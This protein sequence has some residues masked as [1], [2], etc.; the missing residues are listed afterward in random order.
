MNATP[1]TQTQQETVRLLAQQHD[2]KTVSKLSGVDYDLV[3]QW[4]SRRKRRAL[5][6]AGVTLSQTPVKTVADNVQSELQ[7]HE[8][9]TKLGL[10]SYASKQAKHLSEN[11]KLSDSGHFKNV[12]GGAAIVHRWDAKSEASNNVVVNVALLG[13]QPQEV[14]ATV[15][16]VDSEGQDSG[17]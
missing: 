4:E 5:K 7:E 14:S 13:V 8:R 11:G 9:K 16:D 2:L 1:V 15:L 17:E 12:A 6:S 3:R 10:A